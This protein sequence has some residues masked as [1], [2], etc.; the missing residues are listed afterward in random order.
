MISCGE[1]CPKPI[2]VSRL[3]NRRS[4]LT[5]CLLLSLSI[6]LSR[7]TSENKITT[8]LEFHGAA[9]SSSP[10]SLLYVPSSNTVIYASNFIINLARRLSLP[11]KSGDDDG[12]QTI[13]I[14]MMTVVVVLCCTKLI[15]P[16]ARKHYHKILMVFVRLRSS[17]TTGFVW[18]KLTR[19]WAVITAI[20]SV[21]GVNASLT[22]CC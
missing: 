18:L 21:N 4:I 20:K 15:K 19:R 9:A 2:P 13:T 1:T 11:L 6:S 17:P 22:T 10:H 8:N 3:Q 16:C 7:G 14:I 5:L 12:I